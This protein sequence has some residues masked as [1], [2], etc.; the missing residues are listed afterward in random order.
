MTAISSKFRMR[1]NER[2][3]VKLPSVKKVVATLRYLFLVAF[4]GI[5]GL[6]CFSADNPI[7]QG[8]AIV[9]ALFV[10]MFFAYKATS[11]E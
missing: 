7:F 4:A 8:K 5:L 1:S 2:A 10:L 9:A 6:V 3:I 11:K